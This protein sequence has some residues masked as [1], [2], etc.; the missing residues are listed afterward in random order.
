MKAATQLDDLQALESV[1][2]ERLCLEFPQIVYFQVQCLLKER[3]LMVLVQHPVEVMPDR[4][5]VFRVVEEVLG[6]ARSKF[7]V[8]VDLYLRVA[9]KDQPYAFHAFDLEPST[10]TEGAIAL[11]VERDRTM[12]AN[13]WDSSSETDELEAEVLSE[14]AVTPRKSRAGFLSTPVMLAG[15][16]VAL[17]VFG[18]SVYALTRPC[19]IG[20]CQ[21]IQIAQQLSKDATGTQLAAKS[22]AEIANVKQRLETAISSLQSIPAWSSSHS[23]AQELIAGYQK[24][25]QALDIS[26]KGLEAGNMA[27]SKGQNPPHSVSEWKEIQ[28]LWQEAIA[29][30]QQV[31][32]NSSAYPLATTKIKE[33][34]VNLAI[35]NQQAIGENQAQKLLETAKEEAR[36]AK[37][38]QG[39]AQSATQWQQVQ[40]HWQASVSQLQQIEQRTT[41]Y[42]QAQPLL[43]TYQAQL[44]TAGDR[45]NLERTG[46]SNYNLALSSAQKAQS[47]AATN[48]LPDAISQ[49]RDAV[50]YLRQ[51]PSDTFYRHKV[52]GLSVS[53]VQSIKQ[54]QAKLQ[55]KNNKL[56]QAD[57]DL[58]QTC[59]A[60][61]R[62]C[63]YTIASNAI[64]V[65][66]TPDYAQTL[67]Q[68]AITARSKGDYNAQ[69]AVVD[70]VLVFGEALE[71][72]SYNAGLR[73][74]VYGAN[75]A[76]I[77]A[78]NPNPVR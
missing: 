74:E 14:E 29:H 8:S 45:Y 42:K 36:V 69:I 58:Q 9:G 5:Q 6:T 38:L 52:Q 11:P 30:L 59:A 34:Q 61:P 7:P 48:K 37:A 54:S 51:V 15:A 71:A 2:Q 77:Q 20:S 46:A 65:K 78:Y 68:T 40:T 10:G 39:I 4:Q 24:Q 57:K 76:L 47:L 13:P 44:K 60:T 35:A 50:S 43:K 49:W 33:Y 66:L 67:K 28:K 75:G 22:D 19:V 53:Y 73:L 55:L 32:P 56:K 64:K 16:G 62:I 70:H 41:A 31:P 17:A 18:A 27:A 26:L 23:R 21:E 3:K 72:I 1:L 12:A 63:N 25:N